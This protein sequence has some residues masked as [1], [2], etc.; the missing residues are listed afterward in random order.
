MKLLSLLTLIILLLINISGVY[1]QRC[2]D[3]LW[4][5]LNDRDGHSIDPS[6]Y[7]SIKIY[8]KSYDV[9]DLNKVYENEVSPEIKLLKEGQAVLS[10]RTI[11][12][13]I[14]ARFSLEYQDQKMNLIIKNLPG[15][16]G[17]IILKDLQFSEGKYEVD[18]GGRKLDNC[19]LEHDTIISGSKIIDEK[20]WRIDKDKFTVMPN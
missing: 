6:K 15:D 19:Q 4:I 16:S 17:N 11:C 13:L 12:G 3:F 5:S 2:G 8:T 9:N 7:Q 10:I 1:G 20:L 14:E 18:I